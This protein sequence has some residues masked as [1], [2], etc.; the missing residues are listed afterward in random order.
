MLLLVVLAI[1]CGLSTPAQTEVRL[2]S[3]HGVIH[4]LDKPTNITYLITAPPGMKIELTFH[5]YHFFPSKLKDVKFI[6]SKDNR[7]CSRNH[8]LILSNLQGDVD[9]SF[10]EAMM[11]NSTEWMFCDSNRPFKKYLSLTNALQISNVL[12][13]VKT[14]EVASPTYIVHYRFLNTQFSQNGAVRVVQDSEK[15]SSIN[16]Y[17]HTVRVPAKH[18]LR[19]MGKS[20]KC[21]IPQYTVLSKNS[22]NPLFNRFSK[23]LTLNKKEFISNKCT[24]LFDISEPETLTKSD[25]YVEWFLKF[26]SSFAP[27]D[28]E[29]SWEFIKNQMTNEIKESRIELPVQYGFNMSE[30]L[31]FEFLTTRSERK[32]TLRFQAD[33]TNSST[34]ATSES[35]SYIRSKVYGLQE[36]IIP[37]MSTH[38]SRSQHPLRGFNGTLFIKRNREWSVVIDYSLEVNSGD[39]DFDNSFCGY[40]DRVDFVQDETPFLNTNE[41]VHLP[42]SKSLNSY[43]RSANNNNDFYLGTSNQN[44]M[45]TARNVTIYSPLIRVQDEKTVDKVQGSINSRLLTISFNYMYQKDSDRFSLAMRSERL[46]VRSTLVNLTTTQTLVKSDIGADFSASKQLNM[47]EVNNCDVDMSTWRRVERLPIFSCVDFRFEFVFEHDAAN[48][49]SQQTLMGL[50]NIEVNYENNDLKKCNEME[51]CSN[52][53]EC[54]NFND[55][56]TCCCFPGFSGDDCSVQINPCDTINCHNNG[57]C[58]KFEKSFDYRCECAAGYTGDHCE[59]EINECDSEPCGQN[60]RCYDKVG[61]YQCACEPGYSGD[62][63]QNVSEYCEKK[64]ADEGTLRCFENGPT[65]VKCQCKS[66]YTGEI[67]SEQIDECA[68]NPC[69]SGSTC[70]DKINSFECLCP[71]DRTGK[72]CQIKLNF[73]HEYGHL[74]YGNS[75][76]L[77][78]NLNGTEVKC[79]CPY[80]FNGTFCQDRIST[81]NCEPN[82]CNGGTCVSQEVGYVCDCPKGKTGNQCELKPEHLCFGNKCQ[83]GHCLALPEINDYVC[84]C[85][86]N[87]A[88]EFCQ[89]QECSESNIDD[90]CVRNNTLDIIK[91]K[92]FHDQ[93]V[94]KC[95][96]KTG[97]VGPRCEEK[98]DLCDAIQSGIDFVQS[99]GGP[100]I[101]KY[102]ANGGNCSYNSRTNQPECICAEGYTGGRCQERLVAASCSRN[103][104]K[105]GTCSPSKDNSGDYECNCSPGWTGRDCDKRLECSIDTECT[106][107]NTASVKFSYLDNKCIC[108]CKH[109]FEGNDC[110]INHND[111]ADLK[112]EHMCQNGAECIDKVGTYECKC[113]PGFGGYFCETKFQGCNMNPCKYGACEEENFSAFT[114]KCDPGYTGEL[115]DVV[116]DMCEPNPC[117]NGVKCHNLVPSGDRE[118]HDYFCECPPEFGTSS[119]TCSH[120]TIDPCII[121]PC[122]NDATCA[123]TS[124]YLNTPENSK[125]LV[126]SHFTCKCPRGFTGELCE[127]RITSCSTNPCQNKGQCI[128]G[129]VE[130]TFTCRCFPAFTGRLCEHLLD[131]CANFPCSNGA[132]CM[133]TPHGYQ[134][135]CPI[136]YTGKNCDKL[137]SPCDSMK[138][139]NGGEC[140]IDQNNVPF[141]D[142]VDKRFV[143]TQ[144]EQDVTLL[145]NETQ[146]ESVRRSAILD[147]I[148]LNEEQCDFLGNDLQTIDYILFFLVL[149]LLFIMIIVTI[150]IYVQCSIKRYRNSFSK[151]DVEYKNK[152]SDS[153]LNIQKSHH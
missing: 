122:L 50:D 11:T 60:G 91:D 26:N 128:P 94:C 49:S 75:T 131:Q 54:Y 137:I 111:C 15:L 136:N 127:E 38:F 62:H 139:L 81:N 153:E 113:L 125:L 87:Y 130:N 115:C 78:A 83:N 88:G 29:L 151:R 66:G 1:C 51:R 34:N 146:N 3:H 79:A 24:F 33:L 27:Y 120:R 99:Q 105:Y 84:R 112:P 45:N 39:C 6:N 19:F 82:P 107:N 31:E 67:C 95:M 41:I 71:E 142:C 106:A 80:G 14:N 59:T 109:G 93:L 110:S 10:Y 35:K 7:A 53:G 16:G 58:V 47:F 55:V 86:D 123:S 140:Q 18:H 25:W 76:C 150:Y 46:D 89:F 118:K 103:P 124:E 61:S 40:S 135:Q 28:F 145:F 152:D 12:N 72:F 21:Q 74:C 121:S 48:S 43:R 20:N 126:Y 70:V 117:E 77:E 17:L 64:C 149:S 104:C 134:C 108:K 37:L 69:V 116:V 2:T 36:L 143:G 4:S 102:C 97:Y 138:C 5:S 119:K 90:F 100:S 92:S 22:T 44:A 96:C 141:C 52:N 65:N 101:G 56:E 129:H 63:C 23:V 9:K 8:H 57:T 32:Y 85:Y 98:I 73:C 13:G 133:S 147:S 68:S 42:K 114:C 132:T 148:N 144:C 30:E